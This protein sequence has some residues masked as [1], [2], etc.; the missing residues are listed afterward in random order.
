MKKIM[1]I[2]LL[3]IFGTLTVNA[4]EQYTNKTDMYTRI[5][6]ATF[7]TTNYKLN[8]SIRASYTKNGKYYTKFEDVWNMAIKTNVSYENIPN[9][10]RYVEQYNPE[11]KYTKL[12]NTC[13]PA[14][15]NPGPSTACAKLIIDS[16]GFNK[17]P[18]KYISDTSTLLA[19]DR[20]IVYLYSD[21]V[22]AAKESVEDALLLFSNL[23]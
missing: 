14:P 22:R 6:I 7:H 15:A 13:T 2:L 5:Y 17:A 12:K 23:K 20:F 3:L 18:N 21:G 1:I 10:I 4:V 11:V 16:N 9:G 8:S 19:K